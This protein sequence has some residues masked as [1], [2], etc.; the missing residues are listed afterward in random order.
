MS[1][2]KTIFDGNER[3]ISRMRRTVERV[4][5]FE[6]AISALSDDEL[7]AKTPYFRERLAAGET[8]DAMLP[9][10]FAVAREAGKR[11][12]ACATSTCRSSADKCCTK[13]A[14]PR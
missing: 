5:A 13:A 14:S 12:W 4:N 8:L 6:P 9:E 2:F 7:R 11:A 10:V 1:I 3:E